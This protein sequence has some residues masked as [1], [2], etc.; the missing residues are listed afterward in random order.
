M[1]FIVAW[2]ASNET[3][4]VE[5]AY[6]TEAPYLCFLPLCPGSRSVR[7]SPAVMWRSW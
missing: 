6:S 1:S 2:R 3:A 4:D 7:T 5:S